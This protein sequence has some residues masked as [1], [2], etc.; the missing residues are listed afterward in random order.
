ME[1]GRLV[2]S[3]LEC[4]SEVSGEGRFDRGH[5]PGSNERESG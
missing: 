5:D 4:R 2:D 1:S 3:H